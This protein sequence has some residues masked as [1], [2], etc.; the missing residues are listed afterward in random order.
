MRPPAPALLALDWGT[1][2]LR[3]YL[4]G[5]DG[6]VLQTRSNPQGLLSLPLPGAAGFELVFAEVVGGW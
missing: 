3:A 5:M 1:S 2:S 4:L 6:Q